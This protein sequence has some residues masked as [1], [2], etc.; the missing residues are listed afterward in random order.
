MDTEVHHPVVLFRFFL[1][2]KHFLDLKYSV[3][4]NE[5]LAMLTYVGLVQLATEQFFV[6]VF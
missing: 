2:F 6:L 3:S 4:L 5:P 1:L